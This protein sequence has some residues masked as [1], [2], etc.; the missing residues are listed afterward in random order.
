MPN[1]T[2]SKRTTSGLS[3][4]IRPARA[5][6]FFQ[7]MSLSCGIWAALWYAVLTLIAA[8]R[9]PGYNSFSQTVSELSAV[10][11]PTRSLWVWCC[12]AFSLLLL[13]FGRGIVLA[14][15]QNR[16]LRITGILLIVYGAVGIFWPPMHSREVLA[17]GGK[18]M[19]DSLH[20]A[21]TIITSVIILLSMGF[22]AAAT[23]KRFRLYTLFTMALLLLFGMLTSMSASKLETNLPTPWMGVWERVNIYATMLWLAML[24]IRILNKEKM[25]AKI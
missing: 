22:A 5:N 19:T 1:K 15:Q 24:S 25:A 14:A 21:F 2:V 8:A 13:V 18:T 16:A 20:I 23:G 17:K 4:K 9:F 7:R 10:D 11:A 6:V 12:L 3:V